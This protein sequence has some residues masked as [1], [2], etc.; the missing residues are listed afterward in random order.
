MLLGVSVVM[1][2]VSNMERSI[3]FYRDMLGIH[4]AS[5]V[6]SFAFFDGGGTTLALSAA[7]GQSAPSITGATEIVFGV[8]SV[9]TEY[10]NLKSK[11]VKFQTEP[12]DIN[13]KEWAASFTDPDGHLLSIFGPP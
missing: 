13:G 12:H 8:D 1:L 9:K 5:E 7:H 3:V 10:E 4:L 11:G 6:Q 2:G